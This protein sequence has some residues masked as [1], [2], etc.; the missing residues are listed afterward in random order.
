MA[1]WLV[2]TAGIG[3]IVVFTVGLSVLVAYIFMVRWIQ[4]A[5]PDPAPIR[6]EEPETNPSPSEAGGEKA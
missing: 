1:Y 3:S 5:P 6:T 4:T 2:D